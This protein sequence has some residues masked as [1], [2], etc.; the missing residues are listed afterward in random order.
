MWRMTSTPE[1]RPIGLLMAALLT[2]LTVGALIV[3]VVRVDVVDEP[4]RRVR[5]K[6]DAFK[7]LM[8]L[9]V[10]LSLLEVMVYAARME[11]F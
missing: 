8:L 3:A 7:V 11:S 4:V 5:E 2:G 10:V 9:L 6:V 1:G